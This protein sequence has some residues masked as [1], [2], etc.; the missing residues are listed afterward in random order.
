M[1][2]I[3]EAQM[4]DQIKTGVLKDMN[5]IST[6]CW[7]IFVQPQVPLP[8]VIVISFPT[9]LFWMCLG[10]CNTATK[11]VVNILAVLKLAS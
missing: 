11:G 3:V 4:I 10:A 6:S 8:Q 5:T 9:V 1:P 2:E 7:S